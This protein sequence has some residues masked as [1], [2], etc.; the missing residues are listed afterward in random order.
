MIKCVQ[1]LRERIHASMTLDLLSCPGMAIEVLLLQESLLSA[2]EDAVT[3][4]N[5]ESTPGLPHT[6]IGFKLTLQTLFVKVQQQQSL[7]IMQ[8][9]KKSCMKRKD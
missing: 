2:V 7:I 8:I 6:L 3:P 1:D 4:K 5:L 9:E